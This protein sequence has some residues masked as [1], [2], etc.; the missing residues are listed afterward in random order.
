MM[1]RNPSL[2]RN[3]VRFFCSSWNLDILRRKYYYHLVRPLTRKIIKRSAILRVERVSEK[4]S[5]IKPRHDRARSQKHKNQHSL[6]SRVFFR[7]GDYEHLSFLFEQGEFSSSPSSQV[8]YCTHTH[9]SL[10][11]SMGRTG[12]G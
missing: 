2:N 1:C 6:L 7:T 10:V 9:S 12:R 8:I 3:I 4:L 5:L 11:C